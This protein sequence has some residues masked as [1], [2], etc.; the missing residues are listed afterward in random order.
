LVDQGFFV[1]YRERLYFRNSHKATAMALKWITTEVLRF[2][3]VL[4][5]HGAGTAMPCTGG[6]F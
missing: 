5:F 3:L 1:G 6:G 4:V 2:V